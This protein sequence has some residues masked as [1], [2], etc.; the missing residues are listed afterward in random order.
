MDCMRAQAVACYAHK[1]S[2]SCN[3]NTYC[4]PLQDSKSCCAHINQAQHILCSPARQQE[5]LRIHQT[6]TPQLNSTLMLLKSCASLLCPASKLDLQLPPML[7]RT[8]L[9]ACYVEGCK[10]NSLSMLKKAI[11]NVQ[12]R[13]LLAERAAS[14]IGSSMLYSRLQFQ[15][16]LLQ[17]LAI[18][19]ASIF[20]GLELCPVKGGR[21]CSEQS[22]HRNINA[23]YYCSWL[24]VEGSRREIPDGQRLLLPCRKTQCCS[25]MSVCFGCAP[26][27]ACMCVDV[28]PPFCANLPELVAALCLDAHG[29]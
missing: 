25:S 23:F 12:L 26:R 24:V 21:R 1:G 5:L 22:S 7:E 20:V 6:S 4:V 8:Q 15:H 9:A 3:F 2:W 10:A 13:G 17:A 19:F 16:P 18:N 28:Q 14:T 11:A 29:A 27:H